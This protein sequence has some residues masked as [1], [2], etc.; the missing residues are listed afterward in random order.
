MTPSRGAAGRIHEQGGSTEVMATEGASAI[1]AI[2]AKWHLS[3]S[4]SNLSEGE[5]GSEDAGTGHSED[6]DDDFE[7]V[8]RRK[9]KTKRCS[10]HNQG[11]VHLSESSRTVLVFSNQAEMNLRNLNWQLLSDEQE[12][13]APK[14]IKEIRVNLKK[15]IIAIETRT[16]AAV[17]DPLIT[18]KICGTPVRAFLPRAKHTRAGVIG[19]EDT[20]VTMKKIVE[21]MDCGMHVVY[22]RRFGVSRSVKGVFEGDTLPAHVKIEL[23]RYSSGAMTANVDMRGISR[24]FWTECSCKEFYRDFVHCRTH[25]PEWCAYCGHPPTAHNELEAMASEPP[26]WEC[27]DHPKGHQGLK[28]PRLPQRK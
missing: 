26:K 3:G 25:H 7:T 11:E 10:Q 20:T 21:L 14:L 18:K 23:V 16:E 1:P 19:D 8:D 2:P 28:C 13:M 15:N 22:A 9:K 6:N 27:R 24:G 4:Y 5:A 12:T 17:L